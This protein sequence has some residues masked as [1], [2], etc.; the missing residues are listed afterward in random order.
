MKI[1]HDVIPG[2]EKPCPC[3]V[4]GTPSR[5]ITVHD[6]LLDERGTR[7]DWSVCLNCSHD[8]INR[9]LNPFHVQRLRE[10]AGGAPDDEVTFHLHHDFYG[11]NGDRVQ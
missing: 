11:P 10:L 7:I 3:D 8:W 6:F 9:R 1:L 2:R 4:C 5:G